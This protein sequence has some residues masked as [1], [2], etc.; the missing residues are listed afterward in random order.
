M[1]KKPLRI[2]SIDDDPD[3]QRSAAQY[4]TLAGG[5][6]VEVAFS[7]EA[8]VK[9]AEASRPDA[10]ILDISLPDMNG[11]EVLDALHTNTDTRGIPV[12]I[13]TGA[14]LTKA[15]EAALTDKANFRFLTHKPASF[16]EL[17]QRIE[18]AVGQGSGSSERPKDP[19]PEQPKNTDR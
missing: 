12:F 2:L 19:T 7:G 5:H 15:E 1:K 3:C 4:L 8:G 13:L 14:S 18:T 16:A 6:M 10:I 9:K 11:L 17:L